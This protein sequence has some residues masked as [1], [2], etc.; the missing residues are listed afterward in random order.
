MPTAYTADL[1]EGKDVSF[2]NFALT[3]ARATGYF[4][5]L[6]EEP[7]SVPILTLVEPSPY[8]D[9]QLQKAQAEVARI[10]AWDDAE[11]DR[12]ARLTY[13]R[14]IRDYEKYMADRLARRQRYED[15]LAQVTAWTPPTPDHE[16][17]KDFM[18]RQLEDDL[19]DLNRAPLNPPKLLDG[20]AY[21]QQQ[22][23]LAHQNVEY[24]AERAELE[25]ERA[26]ERAE[27]VK[28]LHQSLPEASGT[29]KV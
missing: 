5:A 21:K 20:A 10:A 15:M 23:R 1:D 12:R 3:C 4:M 28:V 29:T 6:R 18:V 8:H 27:W 17:L 11:S 16:P 13:D 19:K 26:R 22:L 7:L 24:H 9:E 25:K 14:A 2:A